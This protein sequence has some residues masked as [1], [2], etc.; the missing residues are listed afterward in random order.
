MKFIDHIRERYKKR[1]KL[2]LSLD[3]LFSILT[4]YFAFRILFE[5]IPL[6][7]FTNSVLLLLAFMTLSI[8]L[9]YLVRVIEMLIMRKRN[10]FALTLGV[11]ILALILAMV[12]FYWI[13]DK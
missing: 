2:F 11:T 13:L 10:Y 12:E 6:N 5:I 9:V 4:L 1:N 3:V 7:Q 8:G